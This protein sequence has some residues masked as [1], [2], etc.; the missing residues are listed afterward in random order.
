MLEPA[1]AEDSRMLGTGGEGWR[2]G[3]TREMVEERDGGGEGWRRRG[4]LALPLS[5]SLSL[6]LP[7]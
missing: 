5:L 4:T 7:L 1:A 2:C 3:G 6:S